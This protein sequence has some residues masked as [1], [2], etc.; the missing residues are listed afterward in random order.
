L[1]PN[2]KNPIIPT[3]AAIARKKQK[4]ATID[5]LKKKCSNKAFWYW[6][7][8]EHT[9]AIANHGKGNC[10]FNHI[11]G[12]PEKDG[13]YLPMFD[14]EKDIYDA[15]QLYD[16]STGKPIHLWI[17]K[18]TGLGVTEFMLRYMAWLA[19][20]DDDNDIKKKIFT[21][22]TG[23]RIDLAID[24][25][26]RFKHL[27]EHQQVTFEDK[28]TVIN[29]GHVKIE[30]FPSHHLDAMR[31]LANVK[32]IL[33][34]EA[35]FF[36]INQQQE[37]RQVA[38][39]YIA[40]SS[41]R[42][43]MVSTPGYPGGI[44][45]QMENEQPSEGSPLYTKLYLPY[46]VGVGNI[47][48]Q[49]DIEQAKKSP[50]FER[51]YNLKYAYGLGNL[52]SEE[53][54]QACIDIGKQLYDPS[55]YEHGKLYYFDPGSVRSIGIDPGFGSSSYAFCVLEYI[56]QSPTA[57]LIRVLYSER[58]NRADIESMLRLAEHLVYTYAPRTVYIDAANPEIAESLRRVLGEQT[59]FDSYGNRKPTWTIYSEHNNMV[60]RI[61]FAKEGA[62]M[63]TMLRNTIQ[64]HALAIH[65]SFIELIQELRVA[66][67]KDTRAGSLDKSNNTMDLVDALRLALRRFTWD[68]P[69]QQAGTAVAV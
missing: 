59:E 50:S 2:Y 3:T 58:H 65:P 69:Q 55:A 1:R 22:V 10:C 52:A 32:F 64:R 30:A 38:E 49:Q 20:T 42:I 57:G 60:Q 48:S 68:D 66:K 9:K 18:A 17:K 15:L 8:A 14:Y 21:I 12:L 24:L 43:A 25:I 51:E 61:N 62:N 33:L 16:E 23:P 31:G 63:L 5:V 44:F 47:Y 7:K 45:E 35:D 13:Q 34:D 56:E 46:T 28:N 39:R 36:P 54:L 29:L 41:A 53:H 11:I 6:D 4:T 27:F 40:K 37:V 26:D 67:E 19:L